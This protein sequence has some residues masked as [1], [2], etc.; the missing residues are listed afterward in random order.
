MVGCGRTE[1]TAVDRIDDD[2][3]PRCF[4]I[5][6]QILAPCAT[7]ISSAPGATPECIN[8]CLKIRFK[9]EGDLA[10]V[11]QGKRI[12]GLTPSSTSAGPS[13]GGISCASLNEFCWRPIYLKST[14]PGHAGD[15]SLR[16]AADTQSGHRGNQSVEIII[17]SI[18]TWQRPLR[19][20]SRSSVEV[21][22]GHSDSR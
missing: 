5:E 13:E 16:Q 3:D 8:R 9:P 12:H 15:P 14:P 1:I 7:P 22:L 4:E 6:S 18:A 17:F 10:R 21:H 20:D 19:V 2:E 11:R